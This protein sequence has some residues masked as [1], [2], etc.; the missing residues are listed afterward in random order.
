MGSAREEYHF[1]TLDS[2]DPGFSLKGAFVISHVWG[3]KRLI[4]QY[5]N[6]SINFIGDISQGNFLKKK[7]KDGSL[8]RFDFH[9]V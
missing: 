2:F 7:I 9:L 4:K 6:K 1:L 3:G 5:L 8:F